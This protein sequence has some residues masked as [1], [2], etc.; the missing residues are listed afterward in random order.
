M[1]TDRRTAIITGASRGIGRA[2]AIR[3][4]QDGARAVLCARD[5]EPLREVQHEVEE[6][7]GVADVLALDL[8]LPEASA[9][10]AEFAMK[11]SGRI[12]IVVNNAGA[13]NRGDFFKLTD[14]DWA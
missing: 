12:D 14:A 9:K 2:I 7:G 8:R 4:A 3:L 13:T 1:S 6:Q 5:A 10:L 11:R